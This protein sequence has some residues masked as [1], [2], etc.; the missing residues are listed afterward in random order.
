MMT[1][2]KD[3]IIRFRFGINFIASAGDRSF[4]VDKQRERDI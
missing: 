3:R 2:V 1:L 4:P